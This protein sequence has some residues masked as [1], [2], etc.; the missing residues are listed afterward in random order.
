MLI[1]GLLELC[2]V[3]VIQK[4]GR[5]LCLVLEEHDFEPTGWDCDGVGGGGSAAS[6][7]SR[8][9]MGRHA[10]PEFSGSRR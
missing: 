9:Q 2:F 3:S 7:V 5:L 8:L 4:H 1:L 6:P 10:R